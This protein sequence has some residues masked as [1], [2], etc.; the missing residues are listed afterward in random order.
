M[1]QSPGLLTGRKTVLP[2]T[3]LKHAEQLALDYAP[4][5]GNNAIAL[6]LYDAIKRY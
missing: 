1:L 2:L 6:A 3:P 5:D 4:F